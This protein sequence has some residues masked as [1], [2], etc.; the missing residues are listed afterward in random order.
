MKISQRVFEL[1]RTRNH[2]G[3]IVGWTDKQMDGQGD[4]YKAPLTLSG[5]ALI[6]WYVAQLQMSFSFFVS[7]LKKRL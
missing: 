1:L 3:Q 5:G 6:T 2:D 7:V 4:Y